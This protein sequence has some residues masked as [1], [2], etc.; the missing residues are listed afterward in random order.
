MYQ[1]VIECEG[2]PTKKMASSC[3]AVISVMT[4]CALLEA[5][6]RMVVINETHQI[7]LHF[8]KRK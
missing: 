3:M 8:Q 7:L 2:F 4:G 6:N 1:M 5:I